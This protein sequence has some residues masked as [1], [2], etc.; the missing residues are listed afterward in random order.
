MHEV[1]RVKLEVELRGGTEAI[2]LR[3]EEG[4]IAAVFADSFMGKLGSELG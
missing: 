1:S 2:R 3:R 4:S